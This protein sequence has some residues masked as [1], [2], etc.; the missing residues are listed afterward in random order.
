MVNLRR[1]VLSLLKKKFEINNYH[2]MG[3]FLD[4][5][6]TTKLKKLMAK[7]MGGSKA[8]TM[9]SSANEIKLQC[10]VIKHDV[11]LNEGHHDEE[12]KETSC[13]LN[14]Y[15]ESNTPKKVKP[16]MCMTTQ[17]RMSP[18]NQYSLRKYFLM[19]K[20]IRLL[21]NLSHSII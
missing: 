12:N 9:W 5:R 1:I 16:V 2:T 20:S 7:W 10:R 3:A 17:T 14:Y 4:P 19:L 8:G 13:Q 21:Q 6:Q 15:H 11:L 18:M